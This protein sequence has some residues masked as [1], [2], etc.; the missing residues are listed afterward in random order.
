ME[1][2]VGFPICHANKL[3]QRRHIKSVVL[4]CA[5]H[6]H[7]MHVNICVERVSLPSFPSLEQGIWCCVCQAGGW[8][9]G[10]SPVPVSCCL[11]ELRLQT[12]TLCVQTSHGFWGFE[13]RSLCLHGKSFY[14]LS[15]LPRF[16]LCYSSLKM[17]SS[18]MWS[19]AVPITFLCMNDRSFNIGIGEAQRV[20]FAGDTCVWPLVHSR[21]NMTD[22][23]TQRVEVYILPILQ[24]ESPLSRWRKDCFLV[25]PLLW[26]HIA[27]LMCTL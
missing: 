24:P 17:L 18:K 16:S 10:D 12:L 7:P 2:Q 8:S 21:W 27:S 23:L 22:W 6:T 4:L 14:P 9:A 11:V 5:L 3:N 25:G 1:R 13:L 20:D 26:L 15:H 19:V